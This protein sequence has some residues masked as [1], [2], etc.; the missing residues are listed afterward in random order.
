MIPKSLSSTRSGMGTGFRIR[1]CANKYAETSGFMARPRLSICLLA[2]VPLLLAASPALAQLGSIFGDSPPR[3]PADVPSAPPSQ[4]PANFPSQQPGNFPRGDVP[5]PPGAIRSDQPPDQPLPA[6]MN[7]PPSSRPGGGT[8]QSQPLPPPP[9]VPVAPL[10]PPQEQ[11][12]QGARTGPVQTLPGLA[13]GERQPRGTPAP[14]DVAPQPGDEIVVEPPPQRIINPTA[15]FSGLDKI[16]GRIISF[17]VAINE[18][19][20]F[21]AL[22][23]TPRVCYSRPPTETPNTD[24]FVE[25]DEVTLQGEIKRIFNGWMFAASPGLHAVEHPVYDVWI[26]DCKG[27]QN[28]AV[29]EAPAEPPKQPARTPPQRQ[30]PP[31]PR[32]QPRTPPP[33]FFPGLR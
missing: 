6:P 20:Q 16:T 23:V 24:A 33:G 2:I 26:T 3:P 13:P 10:P 5:R 27:G 18:T 14:A 12:Q 15:V 9:G 28:P 22:Q 32:T 1:S 4:P 19:V 29:A 8:I 31:P 30:P 17:D 7:L 11:P 25:V 21:G